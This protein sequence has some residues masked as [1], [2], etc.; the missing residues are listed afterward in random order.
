MNSIFARRGMRCGEGTFAAKM[1]RIPPHLM[2]LLFV[3]AIL[4][5]ALPAN[6][7]PQEDHAVY[8]PLVQRNV[9]PHPQADLLRRVA[10][11]GAAGAGDECGWEAGVLALG[12]G[13][14]WQA[15]GDA[16]YFLRLQ[17]W[18]D[19]CIERGVAIAHVNDIPLAYA[20]AVLQA[21][22]PRPAYAALIAAGADYLFHQAPRTQDGAL[23]HLSGMLWDDTL[24]VVIPFL[25]E[26]WQ[27][28]GE[29]QYLDEA[30][31]QVQTHAAHLQDPITGLYHHA[32][33]EGDAGMRSAVGR[34]RVSLEKLGVCAG[35][36]PLPNA[37]DAYS[38]PSYWGRGNGWA[39]WAQAAVLAA[40]PP[41]DARRPALIDAFRR[42]ARALIALQAADQA[43]D[44]SV[45]GQWRTVVTRSDFYAETSATALISAGLLLA[46]GHGLDDGTLLAPA[47]VGAAAVWRQVSADGTVRGVSGPT[48]PMQ[49]EEAYN[50]IAVEEF[51]LYGQGVVLLLG[52]APF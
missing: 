51:T 3:A 5:A 46:A 22:A 35:L 45:A 13:E 31:L 28:T 47:Q 7:A 18:L 24:I 36:M 30:V 16:Q 1:R 52:A 10:E 14:L 12:W 33:M 21:R 50:R 27:S 44:P 2:P 8:L 40:L 4:V 32:W 17:S 48:G 49:E 6:A 43:A 29:A 37:P 20:A 39:L 26:M 11:R 9:T 19:G 34:H 23:I 38:G 42:H 25:L 15:T 41:A